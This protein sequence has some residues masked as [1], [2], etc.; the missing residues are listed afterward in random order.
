MNFS[1]STA[2]L[3]HLPLDQVF[4]IARSVH[5]DGV[6]LAVTWEV[7]LRGARHIQKLIERYQLPVMSVHQPMLALPGWRDMRARMVRSVQLAR[8]LGAPIVVVHPP[9]AATIGDG[10]AQQY[11]LALEACRR[12]LG[13]G[14][15]LAIENPSPL[16]K[17]RLGRIRA[18]DDPNDLRRFAEEQELPVTLDTS[19]AALTSGGLM[20]TYELL[21]ERLVNIHLSDLM[22]RRL[23]WPFDFLHTY[24][25]QHQIPGAGVLPLD[26]LLEALSRRGYDGL[27]TLEISPLAL[28]AWS[29]D[30]ARQGLARGLGYCRRHAMVTE[31]PAG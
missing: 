4:S 28:Q 7:S 26:E 11:L 6:E 2:S 27:V 3:M 25:V 21:K 10:I 18:F 19:H 20:P 15:K 22:A 14:V 29:I 5:F 8:E 12:E 31:R 17:G 16:R 1:V 30:R 24:L 9:P 23:I 13:D